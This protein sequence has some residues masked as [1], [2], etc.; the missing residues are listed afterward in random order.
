MSERSKAKR[1]K[2][3]LPEKKN[4]STILV[5][6]PINNMILK[7]SKLEDVFYS[8]MDIVI[9]SSLFIS[10]C[11][12]SILKIWSPS[13]YHVFRNKLYNIHVKWSGVCIQQAPL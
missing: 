5:D 10:C 6:W 7:V 8:C 2:K 12:L 3:A 1:D 9:L 4:E 11:F 13:I